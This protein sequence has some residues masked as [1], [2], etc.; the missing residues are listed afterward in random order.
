MVASL[1]VLGRQVELTAKE[2]GAGIRPLDCS[3][4]VELFVESADG[5]GFS[6]Y[7]EGQLSVA[8]GV[9][10][11]DQHVDVAADAFGAQGGVGERGGHAEEI[12]QTAVPG[13]S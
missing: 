11:A 13:T 2:G 8:F 12:D 10:V 3:S 1:L 9:A 6:Q 5:R 7:I 4:A